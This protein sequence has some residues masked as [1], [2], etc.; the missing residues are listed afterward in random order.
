MKLRILGEA[1]VRSVID[2][3]QA[4]EIQAKAFAHLSDGSVVSAGGTGSRWYP[5]SRQTMTAA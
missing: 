5:I 4:I 3:G 1:D 2:M